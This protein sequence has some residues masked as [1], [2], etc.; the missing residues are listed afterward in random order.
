MAQLRVPNEEP[1]APG[2]RCGGVSAPTEAARFVT[3]GISI[4]V[5]ILK[6]TGARQRYGTGLKQN[7]CNST[8]NGHPTPNRWS[9]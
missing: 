1:L 2:G 3:I 9:M 8:G 7:Y 4:L 5:Y 6:C